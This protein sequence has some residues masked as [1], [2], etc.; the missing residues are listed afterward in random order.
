M[1]L[2]QR[3]CLINQTVETKD[4][5]RFKGDYYGKQMDIK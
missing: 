4:I 2:L 1:A 3:P 5:L